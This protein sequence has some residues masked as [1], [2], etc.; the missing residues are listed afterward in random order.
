MMNSNCQMVL[1]V[2]HIQDYIE[3]IIKKHEILT[4]IPPIHVYINRINNRLV[5]KIKDG[6]K[7]ELEIPGTMKLFGSKKKK[8][9]R[10]NKNWRK[11]SKSWSTWSSFS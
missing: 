2:S 11:Y 4:T 6:Y 1:I 3:F 10:Q 7:L 8:N 5:F 9:K